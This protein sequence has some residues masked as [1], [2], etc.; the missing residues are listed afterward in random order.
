MDGI[1]IPKNHLKSG[2]MGESSD[3]GAKAHAG[4]PF[5]PI[6]PVKPNSIYKA[7]KHKEAYEKTFSWA[8]KRR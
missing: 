4:K 7:L 6:N 8:K 5:N 3:T 1:L 2:K